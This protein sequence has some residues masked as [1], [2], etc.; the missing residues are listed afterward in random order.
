M[1][2]EE[3]IQKFVHSYHAGRHFKV[4]QRMANAAVVVL[5]RSDKIEDG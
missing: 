3:N 1:Y 2:F 4:I 5:A